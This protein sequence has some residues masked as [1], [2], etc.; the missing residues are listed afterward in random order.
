MCITHS[1]A[2]NYTK[3]CTHTSLYVGVEWGGGTGPT[4]LCSGD[5]PTLA[6]V[7]G[8]DPPEAGDSN[9]VAPSM[10]LRCA[11][12]C[13]GVSRFPVEKKGL[14]CSAPGMTSA[15]DRGAAAPTAAPAAALSRPPLPLGLRSPLMVAPP[16]V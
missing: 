2:R 10:E 9:G 15:G 12:A 11:R 14:D 13:A 1:Q 6:A 8:D 5:A 3:P 16:N 4:H 7:R